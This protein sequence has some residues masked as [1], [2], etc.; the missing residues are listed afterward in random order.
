MPFKLAPS[1]LAS[2]FG[3][4]AEQAKAA[5]DAGADWIHC[6]V[7]DGHFVP[8]IT[9]GP[10]LLE[11]IRKA[12]TVPLDVH[13]MVEHPG[14]MIQGFADAGADYITVH[15]ETCP[16]L[17]GT[18][19]DIRKLGCKAGVTINPG[20]PVCT[21]Q[22]VA[23]DVDL[24]LIMS[25]N[26]GFG[27]QKFIDSALGKLEEARALIDDSGSQAL[28]SIDGGVKADN[29]GRVGAAGV[30]VIVAGSAVYGADDYAAAISEIREAAET[31]KAGT[32]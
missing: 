12:T 7:M 30:D 21:L 15:Q 11:A 24:L 17:H 13:L 25:V 18:I 19:Q 4:V 31:G 10:Q 6:D 3:R 5:E 16:H 22:N 2:D 26:P 27:G 14:R 9:F 23:A 20:T 28:L 8:V 32:P 29:A 1:I